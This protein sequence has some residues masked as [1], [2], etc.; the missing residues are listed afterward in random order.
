M[1]RRARTT[2][3]RSRWTSA[4]DP[5]QLV[6]L[7]DL[8]ISLGSLLV[9]AGKIDEALPHYEAAIAAT[10]KY[11]GNDA[12]ELAIVLLDYGQNSAP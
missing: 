1:T 10:R 4:D 11:F 5:K 9:T 8:H 3:K 2:K 12:I 6:T 7:G